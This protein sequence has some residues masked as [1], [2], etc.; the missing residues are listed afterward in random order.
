MQT[1]VLRLLMLIGIQGL[2]VTLSA[3]HGDSD[4]S[5]PTPTAKAACGNA[6]VADATMHCPPGFVQ[7]KS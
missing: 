2:A 3:C 4:S 5:T 1:P 7:P 6:A